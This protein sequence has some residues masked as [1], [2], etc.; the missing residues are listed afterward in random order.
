MIGALW[1]ICVWR[2]TL[3]YVIAVLDKNAMKSC[4]V[5]YMLYMAVSLNSK[6]TSE[7]IRDDTPFFRMVVFQSSDTFYS[8]HIE[9]QLLIAVVLGSTHSGLAETGALSTSLDL[10]NT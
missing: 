10:R 8:L 3:S 2:S 9:S 4:T 1:R 5:L 6:S 7:T